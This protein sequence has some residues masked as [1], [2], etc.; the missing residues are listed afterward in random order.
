[1]AKKICDITKEVVQTVEQADINE[2]HNHDAEDNFTPI[3]G[4]VQFLKDKGLNTGKRLPE[5]DRQKYLI[6]YFGGKNTVGYYAT[7]LKGM[8]DGNRLLA[9]MLYDFIVTHLPKGRKVADAETG[10]LDLFKFPL[11]NLKV[12]YKQMHGMVN[13]TVP[14]GRRYSNFG[15]IWSAIKLPKTLGWKE[16]TGGIGN[17]A[18]ATRDYASQTSS[19][20]NI[21]LDN[22]N[23]LKSKANKLVY[24]KSHPA[25]KENPDLLGKKIFK[26]DD[27]PDMSMKDLLAQI[28][29]LE[30]DL[31]ILKGSLQD[32]FSMYMGGRV[33]INDNGDFFIYET[34]DVRVDEDNNPMT[35]PT[36]DLM[37]PS[38][39]MYG[40][41]NPV[42]LKE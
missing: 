14:E 16:P 7:E 20:V 31:G 27:L 42:L 24:T 1:M 8:V 22:I 9:G 11:S 5:K 26:K 33:G 23:E 40:F 35:Y 30:T 3:D 41:Y 10:K 21:F 15:G 29:S 25:V 6:E 4:F 38:D 37:V 13:A 32:F 19:R 34:W 36:K 12:Y 28:D 18:R 2:Q 17:L 39:F